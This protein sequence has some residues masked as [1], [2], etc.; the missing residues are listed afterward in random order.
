[1]NKFASLA[2]IAAFCAAPLLAGENCHPG[3]HEANSGSA[4]HKTAIKV[5]GAKDKAYY[6]ARFP[7][8]SQQDLVKAMEAKSVFLVDANGSESYTSGHIPGAVHFTSAGE[9][10]AEM[11]PKEK[12]ALIVAYC[13][14]PGCQAWCKAAD[15]LEEMGYKNIRHYKGGIKEW[16]TAGRAVAK[17]EAQ[18]G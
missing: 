12:D 2:T 17:P 3:A 5:D 10:F 7:E 16:K 1:M 4:V 14:G 15:K 11:L 8:I 13:G 18:K 9:K 6:K